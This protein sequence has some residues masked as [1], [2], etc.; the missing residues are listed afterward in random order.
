MVDITRNFGRTIL[1]KA[2][3]PQFDNSLSLPSLIFTNDFTVLF[4]GRDPG[5]CLLS[6]NWNPIRKKPQRVLD[7]CTFVGP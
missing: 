7:L 5:C 1:D 4:R 3:V 2:A 6:G